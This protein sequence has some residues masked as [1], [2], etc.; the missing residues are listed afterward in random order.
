M[1]NKVNRHGLAAAAL[2]LVFG[3]G[4][5]FAST[6]SATFYAGNYTYLGEFDPTVGEAASF[7]HVNIA[8][9][10][11]NDWWV[12]DLDPSG[13][14]ALNVVFLP[15]TLISNFSLTLHEVVS[16]TCTSVGI[17]CT[18]VT[19]GSVLGASVTLPDPADFVTD[20]DFTALDAGTYAFSITG[21]VANN[22]QIPRSLYSGNLTTQPV[23][24]PATLAL[25]GSGLLFFGR[26]A[27]RRRRKDTETVCA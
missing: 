16:S 7:N 18:G 10:N 14:A 4:A 19:T 6:A 21:T 22:S 11:F 20:F 5:F 1:S 2:G 9:G 13:A 15:T 12:F 8:P 17:A 3:F 27:S 23:P 24:E 25:L 26:F